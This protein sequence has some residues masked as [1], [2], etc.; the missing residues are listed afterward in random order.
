MEV[1]FPVD[2]RILKKKK[3]LVGV[4]NLTLY[5]LFLNKQNILEQIIL[6]RIYNIVRNAAS[7]SSVEFMKLAFLRNEYYRLLIF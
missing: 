5:L 2:V 4:R 7:V 1:V 6:F 3:I